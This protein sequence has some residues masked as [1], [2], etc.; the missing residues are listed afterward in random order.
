MVKFRK[1]IVIVC[2]RLTPI[3]DYKPLL[4]ARP[5]IAITAREAM[6]IAKFF[7]FLRTFNP[8]RELKLSGGHQPQQ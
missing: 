2:R 8:A 4:A 1:I 7:R 5:Q 3:N 6:K